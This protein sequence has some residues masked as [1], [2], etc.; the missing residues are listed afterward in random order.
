MTHHAK[1]DLIRHN[2][3]IKEFES[4]EDHGTPNENAPRPV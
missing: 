1:T 3:L 4:R 2:K